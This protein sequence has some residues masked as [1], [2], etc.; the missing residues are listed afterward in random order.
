MKIF[1]EEHRRKMS[2]SGKKKVFT[3]KHKINMSKAVSGQKNG[4]YGKKHTEETKML[5]RQKFKGRKMSDKFC[6]RQRIS[7]SYSL[8]DYL[9]NHPF[10]CKIEPLR[11]DPTTKEIQVRCSLVS[12]RKWFTPSKSVIQDRIRSLEDHEKDINRFYCS[13]DCKLKCNIFH[14]IGSLSFLKNKEEIYSQEEYNIFRNFV[15]ERDNYECQFCG[16]KAT[17]VHHERPQ[18]LEPF[19]ALDPDY[20]WSCCERCHY[21]FGHKD[22][23]STWRL[24]NKIC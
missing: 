2:E 16:E 17:E 6:E 1:T 7:H 24:A 5:L 9:K 21:K 14:K 13:D 18:K 11:E 3:E 4:F 8:S 15:L 20:A 12:C 10:F 22:E 19:F 23:C